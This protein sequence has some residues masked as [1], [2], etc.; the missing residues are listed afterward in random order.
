MLWWKLQ[1]IK[2]KDPKTL[3]RMVEDMAVAGDPSV[4][5]PISEA[6]SDEAP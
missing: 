1:R 3:R 4:F 2:S 5:E 6:L